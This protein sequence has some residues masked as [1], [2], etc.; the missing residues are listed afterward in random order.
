MYLFYYITRY[1]DIALFH[2]LIARMSLSVSLSLTFSLRSF[3]FSVLCVWFFYFIFSIEHNKW[4]CTNHRHLF[5]IFVLPIQLAWWANWNSTKAYSAFVWAYIEKKNVKSD[6][7][8]MHITWLW[9][10]LHFLAI[11]KRENND[12]HQQCSLFQKHIEI[13]ND[14]TSEMSISFRQKSHAHTISLCLKTKHIALALQIQSKSNHACHLSSTVIQLNCEQNK[15]W[16]DTNSVWT[17]R[18]ATINFVSRNF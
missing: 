2:G 10:R 14:T 4:N 16:F 1:F 12:F 3:V 15:W 11:V 6:W 5:V 13:R 17:T 18:L 9:Y 7:Y 8:R